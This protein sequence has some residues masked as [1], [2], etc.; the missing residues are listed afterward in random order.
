MGLRPER[1]AAFVFHLRQAHCCLYHRTETG[2]CLVGK[3]DHLPPG[4]SSR[5]NM[6]TAAMLA[7][8]DKPVARQ[9]PAALWV[10]THRR[11]YLDKIKNVSRKG[12]R[13]ANAPMGV[14]MSREVTSMEPD[15]LLA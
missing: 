15:T 4:G 10:D 6:T 13:Q 9:L 12:F 8:D 3:A 2:P 7:F 14:G 1:A 5:G 11:S